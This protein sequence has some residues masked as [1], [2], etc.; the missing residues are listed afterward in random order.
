MMC[1]T[2]AFPQNGPS[3]DFLGFLG[4]WKAIEENQKALEENQ[5]AMAESRKASRKVEGVADSRK[6]SWKAESH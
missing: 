3:I 4:K 1:G 2:S 5:K 6:A